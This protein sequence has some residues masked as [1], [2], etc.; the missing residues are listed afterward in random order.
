MMSRRIIPAND[1]LAQCFH[2]G[3]GLRL[4]FLFSAEKSHDPAHKRPRR[5]I[6][7]IVSNPLRGEISAAKRR[8]V[9]CAHQ[10]NYQTNRGI[11]GVNATQTRHTGKGPM[12]SANDSGLSIL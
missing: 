5:K 12:K 8:I 7:D 1:D 6:P 9:C 4:V 10:G 11:A 3:T 2:I